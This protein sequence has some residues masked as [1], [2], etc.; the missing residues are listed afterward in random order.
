MSTR[1]GFLY[2]HAPKT[3]GNSILGTLLPFSDDRRVVVDHMDGVDRLTITGPVTPRKHA[4]LAEYAARGVNVAGMFVF[5]SVRH[6]FERA[7]SFYFSPHRWARQGT[8][9]GWYFEA[10]AWNADA[11]AD[12]IGDIPTM[13][14]FLR[15]GATIRRPDEVI[16]MENI[17]ADFSRVAGRIGVPP[18]LVLPHRNRAIVASSVRSLGRS[19]PGV[20]RLVEGRFA[21][22]M[23]YF[24]Y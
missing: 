24:G 17:S 12:F 7:L 9:G 13:V 11:F 22:D 8:D 3:G 14:D 21:E 4:R 23:A 6:P 5:I 10:P 19:D 2:L 16:R 18:T 15:V 20:R 1:Y